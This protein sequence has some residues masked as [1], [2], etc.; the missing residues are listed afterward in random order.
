MVVLGYVD[1]RKITAR[2]GGQESPAKLWTDSQER[3]GHQATY[4]GDG[5][6]GHKVRMQAAFVM[7]KASLHNPRFSSEARFGLLAPRS[8]E[9][10]YMH[11]E[12]VEAGVTCF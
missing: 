8:I 1:G 7:R 5:G 3:P 9:N 11:S 6:R 2:K 4:F 12:A 10:K